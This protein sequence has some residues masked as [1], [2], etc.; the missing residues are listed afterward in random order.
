MK[1]FQIRNGELNIEHERKLERSGEVMET[2]ESEEE[3]KLPL[4]RE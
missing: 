2:N 1:L 4:E 3:R